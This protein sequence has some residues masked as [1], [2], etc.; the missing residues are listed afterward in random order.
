MAKGHQKTPQT[1]PSGQDFTAVKRFQLGSVT[2][3]TGNFIPSKVLVFVFSLCK[4]LKTYGKFAH[5]NLS[6]PL[7][8]SPMTRDT[9]KFFTFYPSWAWIF[10]SKS[11]ASPASSEIASSFLQCT[12]GKRGKGPLQRATKNPGNPPRRNIRTVSHADQR[13][14]SDTGKTR[15]VELGSLPAA[16]QRSALRHDLIKGHSRLSLFYPGRASVSSCCFLCTPHIS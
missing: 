7:G 10:L 2:L 14:F 1:S 8:T 3:G 11:S 15:P 5:T 13:R 6:L 9:P 12:L 16:R 4:C